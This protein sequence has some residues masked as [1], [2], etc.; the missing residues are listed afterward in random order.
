MLQVERM[1]VRVL[2]RSLNFFNL[3]NPSSH[4]VVLGFPQSLIQMSTRTTFWVITDPSRAASDCSHMA[5][6][7]FFSDRTS[8][9]QAGQIKLCYKHYVT[10]ERTYICI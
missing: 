1:R 7:R 9:A 10:P 4:I 6:L 3:P 5:E 2:M 8:L